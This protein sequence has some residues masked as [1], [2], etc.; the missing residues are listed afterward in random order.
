MSAMGPDEAL[1][2]WP[3]AAGDPAAGDPAA[4]DPAHEPG[5]APDADGVVVLATRTYQPL[6]LFLFSAAGWHPHRIHYDQ[7]YT[8]GVEGHE[9]VVVHGPLQTVHLVDALVGALDVPV[10]VRTI[11]SRHLALLTVG[12]VAVVKSRLHGA[13]HDGSSATFEVWMERGDGARTT[14]VTATVERRTGGPA[15]GPATGRGTGDAR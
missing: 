1:L 11:A 3:T 7:P 2:R 4:G 14:T 5:G 12:E 10:D 15:G 6:E 8:T 13:D 9:A